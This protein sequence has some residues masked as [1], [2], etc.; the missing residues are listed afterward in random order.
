MVTLSGHILDSDGNPVGGAK[1]SGIPHPIPEIGEL[2]PPTALTESDEDGYFEFRPQ[3]GPFHFHKIAGYLAGGDPTFHGQ[4][5]FFINIHAEAPGFQTKKAGGPIPVISPEQVTASR[6]YG[7]ILN[8]VLA[9]VDK[10]RKWEENSGLPL[11]SGHDNII[12]D[13]NVI[14]ERSEGSSQ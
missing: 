1:V 13:I 7:E 5:S 11:P 4:N 10:E 9:K 12:T 8:M 14:L 2:A 6:R 3:I